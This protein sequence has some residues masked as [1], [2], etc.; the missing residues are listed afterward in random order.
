MVRFETSSLTPIHWLAIAL[1]AISG[2]IHLLLAVIFPVLPF[3]VSF[4]LAGLGFF[5]GIALVLVGYRRRLIYAIGVPFTAVQIVLWYLVV[6]PTLGS[7][8]TIDA[9]DK[10]AQALL[11]VLL[12]ALYARGR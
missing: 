9:I 4:V 10:L 3:Q 12:V 1:A 5:G 11:I 8:D 6:G 2:L 7:L